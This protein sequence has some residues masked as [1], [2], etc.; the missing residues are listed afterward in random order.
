MANWNW[1]QR[2]QKSVAHSITSRLELKVLLEFKRY[3]TK[4]GLQDVGRM[5]LDVKYSLI[6]V[7]T[8]IKVGETTADKMFT[9][10]EVECLGACVNAPMVQINDN[11]Y[12]SAWQTVQLYSFLDMEPN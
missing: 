3:F 4:N 7:S 12:V 8:G 6:C 1:A 9:L 11:Y 5:P 2:A 10:I